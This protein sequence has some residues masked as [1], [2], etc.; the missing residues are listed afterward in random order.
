M[1]G[2]GMPK[3]KRDKTGS[4]PL[5]K[6][7]PE[8]V[9]DAFGGKWEAKK[10]LPRTMTDGEAK[11]AAAAFYSDL[12]AKIAAVRAGKLALSDD[13]INALAAEWYR[14]ER[15]RELTTGDPPEAYGPV[16]NILTGHDGGMQSPTVAGL[17]HKRAAET[18]QHRN[19]PADPA[20]IDRLANALLPLHKALYSRAK[21]VA[22]GEHGPDPQDALMAVSAPPKAIQKSPR[23]LALFEKWA[24]HP[25]QS[26]NAPKTIQ[27]YRGVFNT[28]AAHLKNPHAASVTREDA[29]RYF[30]HLQI[31]AGHKAKTVRDVHKAALSSV[32]GWAQGKLIIADNPFTGRMVKVGKQRKVRPK[33]FTDA[34]AAMILNAARAIQSSNSDPFYAAARRWVPVLLAYTGARVQEITQLRR[35]DVRQH[36][37]GFWFLRL[38]PDAGTIKSGVFREVPLHPRLVAEGFVDF[39]HASSDGPL[40]YDPHSRR[41][42]DAAVS[43]AENTAKRL[44]QWVRDAVGIKDPNVSPNHAWRHRF[45]TI[46][47]RTGIEARNADAITGHAPRTEGEAYGEDALEMLFREI[48]K[49]TPDLVEGAT[50]PSQHAADGQRFK[51]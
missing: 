38:T 32:F 3:I 20:S 10:T 39:R 26:Q 40:F 6:S 29:I 2:L 47:R 34:E 37:S 44:V 48:C 23:V 15:A 45:K 16:L 14:E 7:I 8:D 12:E 13:E 17:M 5:R 31:E 28:F 19:I 1:A 21:A 51:V 24:S 36:P 22:G 43:L 4:I 18:L 30:D 11:A 49:I 25:E 35:E 33:S 27:R 9:R 50:T 42:A 46:S 41:K